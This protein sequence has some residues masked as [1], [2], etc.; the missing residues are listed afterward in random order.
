[1]LL[2]DCAWRLL[3]TIPRPCSPHVRAARYDMSFRVFGGGVLVGYD[4]LL[5]LLHQ[6]R[7]RRTRDQPQLPPQGP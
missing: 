7:A 6:Q 2:D 3:L 1:M 4:V 5:E